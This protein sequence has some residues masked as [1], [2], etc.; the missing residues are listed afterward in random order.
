MN[1][2]LIEQKVEAALGPLPAGGM[3]SSLERRRLRFYLGQ[4][5][6]D[7]AALAVAF[8]L[9]GFIYIGRKTSLISVLLPAQLLL[10]IFLTIACRTVLIRSLLYG[11]G[12]SGRCARWPRCWFPR[13][14]S[15][16]WP[17]SPR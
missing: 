7:I 6:G 10:P 15:I 5:V 11:A 17:S 4:I 16:S 2:P 8:I 14:C 3:A 12:M 9:A 1:L 13:R